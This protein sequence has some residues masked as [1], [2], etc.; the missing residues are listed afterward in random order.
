[1]VVVAVVGS[2]SGT[3]GVR[4]NESTTRGGVLKFKHSGAGTVAGGDLI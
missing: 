4:E 3:Q 2:S 1:M